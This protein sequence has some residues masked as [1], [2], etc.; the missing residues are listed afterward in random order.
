MVCRWGSEGESRKRAVLGK[1]RCGKMP[2]LGRISPFVFA[3]AEQA[4]EKR[5][6]SGVVPVLALAG[7]EARP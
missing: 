3:G 1:K 7:A 2:D 5:R 4:G 6:K